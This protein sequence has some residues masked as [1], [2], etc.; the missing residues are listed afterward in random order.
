M[1]SMLRELLSN[2]SIPYQIKVVSHQ[3]EWTGS[4]VVN[5]RDLGGIPLLTLYLSLIDDESSRSLF[6]QI[7]ITHRDTMVYVA[8]RIL[9]DQSLAEDATH[10]AFLRIINHL[11]KNIRS[12]LSQNAKLR[13]SDSKEHCF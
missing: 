1:I 6:E 13:R 9:K 10:D 4:D 2:H 3:S 8:Q 11:E 12:I 7:Y 5:C